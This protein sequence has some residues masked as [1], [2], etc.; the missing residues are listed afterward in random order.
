MG[1]RNFVIDP[2]GSKDFLATEAQSKALNDKIRKRILKK[3]LS[4]K[5]KRIVTGLSIGINSIY[6]LKYCHP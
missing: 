5:F 3:Y 6:F 2:I 1:I 4:I